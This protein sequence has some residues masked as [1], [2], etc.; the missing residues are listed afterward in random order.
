[1]TDT[2]HD[3]LRAYLGRSPTD[4]ER[5]IF[6]DQRTRVEFGVMSHPLWDERETRTGLAARAPFEAGQSA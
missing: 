2:Q 4:E 1:M 3:A 6:E 5:A